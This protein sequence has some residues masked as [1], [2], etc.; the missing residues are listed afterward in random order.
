MYCRLRKNERTK[1]QKTK[2]SKQGVIDAP[3]RS[4]MQEMC[5]RYH[6]R[7]CVF[8]TA[9]CISKRKKKEKKRVKMRPKEED[10]KMAATKKDINNHH[11]ASYHTVSMS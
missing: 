10:K 6:G 11:I 3:V 5:P 2:E 8:Q 7:R 9:V 1:Q 4:Q